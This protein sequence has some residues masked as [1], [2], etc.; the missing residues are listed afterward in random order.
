MNRFEILCS[1]LKRTLFLSCIMSWTLFSSASQPYCLEN[2]LSQLLLEEMST[3]SCAERKWIAQQA[4]TPHKL[5]SKRKYSLERKEEWEK[6]GKLSKKLLTVR[7]KEERNSPFPFSLSYV[8]SSSQRYIISE[9]PREG[10]LKAFWN[11][12]FDNGVR[13]IVTLVSPLEENKDHLS[14][15]WE[16]KNFPLAMGDW[17]IELVDEGCVEKSPKESKQQLISRLFRARHTKNHEIRFFQQLHY[18]NWPDLGR[19]DPHLL[20]RLISLSIQLNPER[21]TPLFVH[22]AAGLGRSGTFA[23][24]H[25]LSKEIWDAHGRF[26]E[27]TTS[28][29]IPEKLIFLRMQRPSLVSTS[30]QY[31]SI[32][33]AVHLFIKGMQQEGLL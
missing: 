32:Y 22:C 14:Q 30:G 25:S 8:A 5:S 13:L 7:Q 33:H 26:D 11:S 23:T 29:N 4:I 12:L 28:I 16:A 15:F 31:E 21:D 10:T 19:P 9:S 27:K 6:M 3:L 20:E 17:M 18:I 2:R 1:W 24:A